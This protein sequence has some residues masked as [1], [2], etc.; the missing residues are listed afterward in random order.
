MLPLYILRKCI[1][2]KYFKKRR[3]KTPIDMEKKEKHSNVRNVREHC[4]NQMQ[5]RV[6]LLPGQL[7]K[8]KAEQANGPQILA[9]N[10][11][12]IIISLESSTL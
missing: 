4:N 7:Y 9:F 3:E 10:I 6:Y 5:P 12:E 11:H 8:A 2:K 1:T